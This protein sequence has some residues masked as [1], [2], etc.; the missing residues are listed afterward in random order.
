MLPTIT[1]PSTATPQVPP[2]IRQPGNGCVRGCRLTVG[3]RHCIA[4]MLSMGPGGEGRVGCPE[5]AMRMSASHGD[6]REQTRR[7]VSARG[8]AGGDR[9]GHGKVRGRAAG[10]HRDIHR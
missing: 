3:R 10:I 6:S 5:V 1:R 2:D 9:G 8:R 7:H 4:V